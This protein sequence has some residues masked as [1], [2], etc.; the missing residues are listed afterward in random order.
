MELEK[1]TDE[2]LVVKAKE[3]NNLAVNVLARRYKTVVSA[4][5]HSYFLVGCDS[6]DLLQEGMIAVVNAISSYKGDATFKTYAT[7]CIRNRI[8]SLIRNFNSQK[9]KPLNNYVSLSGYLDGDSDKT[10]VIIAKTFGP[11]ET[12]INK[13]DVEERK[14]TI[15]Q[16]LSKYEYKILQLFLSGY[17]YEKISKLINKNEKSIDNALQRIRK[18]LSHLRSM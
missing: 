7:T 6:E 1:L 4:I 18:K 16:S 10:D 11:E 12:Y 5:T 9:N 15:E 8:F 14:K 17:S 13:E 3:G 2:E